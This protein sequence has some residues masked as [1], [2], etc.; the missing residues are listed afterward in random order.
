MPFGGC[1]CLGYHEWMHVLVVVGSFCNV[2]SVLVLT[3]LSVLG[4]D[5]ESSQEGFVAQEDAFYEPRE[6]LW[7]VVVAAPD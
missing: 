1:A 7:A 6:A 3:Q 2:M 5:A 4:L